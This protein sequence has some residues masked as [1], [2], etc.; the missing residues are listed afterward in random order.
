M[1]SLNIITPMVIVKIDCEK[2]TGIVQ[3]KRINAD[4][5]LSYQVIVNSLI[6]QWQEFSAIASGTF[7]SWFET[8]IVFPFIGTGGRIARLARRWR[9]PASRIHIVSTTKQGTKES[10]L[11][12]GRESGRRN[13]RDD[14]LGSMYIFG[15]PR[16]AVSV[17]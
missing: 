12:I 14:I 5:L 4:G 17:Q 3:K 11:V 13:C 9:F 6:C 16:D 15:F 8:H 10:N 1:E 7:D 2:A